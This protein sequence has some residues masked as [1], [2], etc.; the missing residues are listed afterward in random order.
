M[1]ANQSS[2]FYQHY[3]KGKTMDLITK[4]K[5][6]SMLICPNKSGFPS[7][8]HALY[9]IEISLIPFYADHRTI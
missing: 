9:S 4:D 6:S 7:H 2:L 5:I 3:P 8:C 1:L